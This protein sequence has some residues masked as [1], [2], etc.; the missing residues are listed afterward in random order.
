MLHNIWFFGILLVSLLGSNLVLAADANDVRVRVIRSRNE[1]TIKGFQLSITNA[2]SSK[3]YI[4]SQ[5][6]QKATFKLKNILGTKQWLVTLEDE[7]ENETIEKTFFGKS[8]RI[9]GN[10][11]RSG[12]K[13][14]SSN[15]ELRINRIHRIDG[16][17]ELKLD[18]YLEG[19]L[20]SEMPITWPVE[21][22]KAQA[23]ASR[24]YTL[25]MINQNRDKD[26]QLESSIYD[27]VFSLNGV[28]SVKLK[29]K[30]SKVISET[31]GMLLLNSKKNL[32]P[33]YYHA[34]CGG[35]TEEPENVWDGRRTNGTVKDLNCPLSPNSLWN[36]K[37]S[38]AKLSR[39]LKRF[40]NIDD[41]SKIF[42]DLS[43]LERTKSKRVL[44]LSVSFDDGD[45]HRISGQNLRKIFGFTKIKSTNFSIARKNKSLHF[46][47]KGSGH[48]VGLCQWGTRHLAKKGLGFKEILKHYY[49]NSIFN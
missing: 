46:F 27:Q 9:S 15:L 49:P 47:G 35:E 18:T 37:V 39:T 44:N 2:L 20:P 48:G 45:K 28:E 8:V 24:S 1:V 11:L 10:F 4:Q 5:N 19:V 7:L 33:G 29:K 3:I 31:S 6:L 17:A 26:Y 34:D 36:H 13:K 30:L 32:L 40:L 41:Q 21:A 38:D 25:Y 23:V 22:L 12:V 14:L 43:V 42:S 16:I